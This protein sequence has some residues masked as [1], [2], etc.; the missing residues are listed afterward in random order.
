MGNVQGKGVNRAS[1]LIVEHDLAGCTA[2]LQWLA[3]MPAVQGSLPCKA[4]GTH[5]IGLFA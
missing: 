1:H 2:A 4:C 5:Q 3:D